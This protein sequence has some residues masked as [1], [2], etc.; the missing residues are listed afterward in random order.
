MTD[1]D[2]LTARLEHTHN[3]L[4]AAGVTSVVSNSIAAERHEARITIREAITELDRLSADVKRLEGER[5]EE[6]CCKRDDKQH[7]NCWYDGKACC[8]C[9]VGTDQRPPAPDLRAVTGALKSAVA[10]HGPITAD[11]VTSAAKRIIGLL[12][13]HKVAGGGSL[14]DIRSRQGDAPGYDGEPS[15]SSLPPAPDLRGALL[16]LTNEAE[17]FLSMADR[18][19]HGNTNIACLRFHIEKSRKALAATEPTGETT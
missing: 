13:A 9:G 8:A 7:C 18:D 12:Y 3:L 16:K 19:T 4:A 5:D 1:A 10:A 2:T 15:P 6:A 17:G 14:P 11:L